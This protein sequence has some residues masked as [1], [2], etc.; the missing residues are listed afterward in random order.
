MRRHM[1]APTGRPMSILVVASLAGLVMMLGAANAADY[2][3]TYAEGLRHSRRAAALAGAN[4]CKAAVS[5]YTKAIKLLKDPV[6]L[7][8]RAECY[9]TLGDR[10]A[11]LGDYRQFLVELPKTPNRKQVEAQI[12]ALEA[13]PK[14]APPPAPTAAPPPPKGAA[15][16]SVSTPAPAEKPVAPA[17]TPPPVPPRE[18][19]TQLDDHRRDPNPIAPG[20]DIIH[21]DPAPMP[22]APADVEGPTSRTSRWWIWTIAAVVLAGGGVTT[23][24]LLRGNK[25][26]SPSS[27]LG[28]YRF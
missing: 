6:L 5:E 21:V 3:R 14:P 7:F 8:N 11:A 27:D 28:N 12:A 15:H 19:I 26:D 4:N 2:T 23:Y 13:P 17:E 16:A 24:L 18:I 10:E 22:L 20:V 9:R 1:R 25:T